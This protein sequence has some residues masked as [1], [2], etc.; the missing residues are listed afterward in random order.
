MIILKAFPPKPPLVLFHIHGR[1][2]KMEVVNPETLD[3]QGLVDL[4]NEMK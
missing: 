3:R 2:I 1:N 4:S